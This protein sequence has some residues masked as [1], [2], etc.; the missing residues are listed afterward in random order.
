MRKSL[1]IACA[2]A[3]VLMAAS[4]ACGAT[5]SVHPGRGAAQS[6]YGRN[7]ITVATPG[8]HGPSPT[9]N[10]IVWANAEDLGV[11][12]AELGGYHGVMMNID[13]Q[14]LANEGAQPTSFA[15][16]F[17]E[18]KSAFPKTPPWL[19]NTIEKNRS[20]IEAAC[21]QDHEAPFKVYTITQ[22][23]RGG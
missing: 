8:R 1:I 13:L 3:P 22:R 20:G 9:A 6:E 7:V 12:P 4:L 21:A 5:K 14:P 11:G 19:L 15:A 10:C 18:L 16:G 17:T 23:D 2:V